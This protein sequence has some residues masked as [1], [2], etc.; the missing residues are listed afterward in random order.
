MKIIADDMD[1]SNLIGSVTWSGDVTQMARKLSFTYLYTDLTPDIQLVEIN[2]GSRIIAFDDDNNNI[3]DGIV[4]TEEFDESDIKKSIQAADYA[5]YLKS[6]VYGEF[7]G[8]PAQIVNKVAALF[9]ISI[10][11]LPDAAGDIS[12]LAAGDKTIYQV[13][14][15]AYES[16][17]EGI[18]IKMA[19]T[20]LNV[21]KI[22]SIEVGP[23]TGDDFVTGAKYKSSIENMVNRVAIIDGNSSL[24]NVRDKQEDLIYGIV[25]EVYKHDDSKKD[26]IEEAEKLFKS[27]ENSGSITI[28]GDYRIIAG[29]SVIV[30]KVSSQIQGLFKVTS[31]SH[32]ISNGQHTTTVTLDF[33]KVVK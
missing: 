1:V 26:A 11:E 19:G 33:T 32:S 3:F 13:I 5:F 24:V 12:I 15:E 22:G 16:V 6:K 17:P 25:Q 21:E 8:T 9:D 28:N 20:T 27:V 23:I 29:R 31:D 30:E 10:G 18:Y 4:I 2:V 7:N 14:E